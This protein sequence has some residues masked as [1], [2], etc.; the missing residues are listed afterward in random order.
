MQHSSEYEV[1]VNRS[2]GFLRLA[3]SALS[4]GL[5]DLACFLAEQAVQLYIKAQL[6]RLAGDYP[7]THHIRQLMAR[8][9]EILPSN[10]R[11]V[12]QEY[13]KENRARLSE[14]EDAYTMSRYTTKPYTRE[15][16]KDSV[17]FA[18]EIMSK[19][20]RVTG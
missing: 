9:L 3:E 10:R 14:L 13:L 16:A 15:D 7:R 12:L 8:L 20:E 19:V 1:M 5:Y 4:N 11:N 6:L 17:E 18:R 2:K